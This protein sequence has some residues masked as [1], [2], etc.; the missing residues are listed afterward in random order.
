[1]S[2]K[3]ILIP[4]WSTGENSFGAGKMYLNYFGHFGTVIVGTPTK[5][6][7]DDINLVILP[8]GM[9][10]YA[11]RYRQIPSYFNT[12]PDLFKEFFLDNNLQGYIDAG[13]PVFGICLG[14]QMLQAWAGGE[15]EQNVGHPYSGDD[16]GK[17]VHP[18]EFTEQYDYLHETLDIPRKRKKEGKIIDEYKVNSLH[19]QGIDINNLAECF[20]AVLV[21]PDDIVEAFVH[22]TLPI[23]AVQYHPE[24]SF[25][26]TATYLIN[27]LLETGAQAKIEEKKEKI[28]MAQ[29]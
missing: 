12:N 14:A 15:L 28:K 7:F 25:D 21:A 26:V 1:M 22:R 23:A 8:G 19:H 6:I 13:V 17:L 3:K 4:G 2:N 16:R 11:N 27:Q 20:E 10:T 18:V 29:S 24:E 9:D 5:D